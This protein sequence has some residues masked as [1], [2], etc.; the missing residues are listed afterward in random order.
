MRRLSIPRIP[1]AV[2]AYLLI[3]LAVAGLAGSLGVL[4]H[5]QGQAEQ[6]NRE[7]LAELRE[8][9]ETIQ[10][11]LERQAANDADRQRLID[12]A[13]SAIAAEQRRALVAHD[14]SVKEYLE[15]LLRRT[16][17]LRTRPSVLVIPPLPARAAPA[18]QVGPA[19][20]RPAPQLAPA[21]RP[22]PAPP[23]PCQPR[24]KSGKCKR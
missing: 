13:V 15:R 1:V 16:D 3:A 4:L 5:R 19:I 20:P 24:G 17:G 18:P 22:A 7:V 11:L 8:Q 23:P 9:N 6:Q 10:S 2:L 12:D 14:H 21:P